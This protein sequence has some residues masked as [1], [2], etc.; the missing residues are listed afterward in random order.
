MIYLEVDYLIIITVLITA[1]IQSIFGVGVLLFGT[2]TLLILNFSFIDCLLILLPISAIIN[3][4]QVFKNICHIDY[5]IYKKL[6]IYTVPSIIISLFFISHINLEINFIIGI[7]LILI[8]IKENSSVI[9]SLFEKFLEFHKVFYLFMGII[10]GLTNLGGALLTAR[11]FFTKLNKNQK[12]ATIAISYMTFALFQMITILIIDF[13]YNF[14]Y[15][16]YVLVGLL[17][18]LMV[19]KIFF[20]KISNEKY[21]K[22]FSLFLIVSGFSLIFKGFAW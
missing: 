16:I 5:G 1:F 3:F 18:Y 13:N 6:L 19:N 14:I 8:A 9:K 17:T 22:F 7:F 15:L 4:L 10:H 11:I 20:H 21:N 2:P 12:R